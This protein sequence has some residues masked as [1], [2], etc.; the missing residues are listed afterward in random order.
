MFRF[1]KL[2]MLFGLLA[3]AGVGTG[4]Q[5]GAPDPVKTKFDRFK[6]ETVISVEP[7]SP[8]SVSYTDG[9]LVEKISALR[10]SLVVD[11]IGRVVGTADPVAVQALFFCHGDAPSCASELVSLRFTATTRWW[12]FMSG[13]REAIALV[14]G[15]PLPTVEYHWNG[16]VISADELLEQMHFS[17][18]APLFNKLASGKKV[19]VLLGIYVMTLSADTLKDFRSLGEHIVEKKKDAAKLIR[20]IRQPERSA[21]P[22]RELGEAAAVAGDDG[23]LELGS[24]LNSLFGLT[25]A[26]AFAE[27]TCGVRIP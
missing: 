20:T 26:I 2:L 1:S 13:P 4:A 6:N 3:F 27:K 11:A 14:D 21:V 18:P 9:R 17:L 7:H 5:I 15:V 22:V 12:S 24:E 16:S 23:M 10:P 8:S 19:E 25:D